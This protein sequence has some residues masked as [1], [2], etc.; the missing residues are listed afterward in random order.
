MRYSSRAAAPAQPQNYFLVTRYSS[1]YG[2][3]DSETT[4][5]DRCT[6][7]QEKRRCLIAQLNVHLGDTG[8]AGQH[9]QLARLQMLCEELRADPV[10]IT[11]T[12]CKEV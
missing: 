5:R 6:H 10:P 3:A 7:A 9:N 2:N 4:I 8:A 12:K 11:I 1:Q